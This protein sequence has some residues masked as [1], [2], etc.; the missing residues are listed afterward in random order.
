MLN[1][2]WCGLV[3]PLQV[4]ASFSS[5]PLC[6]AAEGGRKES[7]RDRRESDRDSRRDSDRDRR[8]DDS[9]ETSSGS[10][11]RRDERRSS[12]PDID[13][14]IDPDE[15]K[16]LAEKG[17]VGK[18]GWD[19]ERKAQGEEGRRKEEEGG[20][21]RGEEEIGG[22]RVTVLHPFLCVETLKYLRTTSRS[23]R[24]T[25]LSS[26]WTDV[27]GG[28]G[29]GGRRV[30]SGCV[31]GSRDAVTVSMAAVCSWSFLRAVFT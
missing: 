14:A 2:M 19:R 8:A 5:L 9:M 4:L 3:F 17:G 13:E 27:R 20:V 12:E 1:L 31:T 25:A 30:G 21:G 6:A 15:P 10:S 11:S 26:L 22:G 18:E 16:G 23:N 28:R 7:D 24:R 29:R